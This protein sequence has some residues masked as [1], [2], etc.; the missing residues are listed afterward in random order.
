MVTHVETQE[1]GLKTNELPM[2]VKADKH[3]E[4]RHRDTTGETKRVMKQKRLTSIRDADDNTEMR[5][6]WIGHE[7]ELT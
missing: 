2:T 1:T 4:T 5:L 6:G 3:G 7:S